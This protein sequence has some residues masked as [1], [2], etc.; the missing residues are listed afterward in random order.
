MDEILVIHDFHVLFQLLNFES[1]ARKYDDSLM[2]ERCMMISNTL[3]VSRLVVPMSLEEF[4][5]TEI[6]IEEFNKL[7]TAKNP[8]N[9]HNKENRYRDL[10][11]VKYVGDHKTEKNKD[12]DGEML[13]NY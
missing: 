2:V 6:K 8:L 3:R 1:E 4:L 12:L 13:E 9:I 5:V 10:E 7:T 11:I